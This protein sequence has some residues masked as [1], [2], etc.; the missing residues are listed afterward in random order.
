MTAP[1]LLAACVAALLLATTPA[2]AAT[3]TKG[4]K[5]ISVSVAGMSLGDAIRL[6]AQQGR[7]DVVL[8]DDLKQIVS[9]D[10]RNVAVQD[11]LDTLFDMGG[12]SGEER[13]ERVLDGH[14]AEV[15]A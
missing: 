13:V 1:R 4:E 9:V 14:V 6:V 7:L 10:F 8:E 5:R 15:D 2:M 11:A 3:A 12:V